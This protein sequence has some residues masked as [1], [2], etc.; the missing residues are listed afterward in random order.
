MPGGHAEAF[1]RPPIISLQAA[2]SDALLQKS[3][4]D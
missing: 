4:P 1:L 2:L 3:Q